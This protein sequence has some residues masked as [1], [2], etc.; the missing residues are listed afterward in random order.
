MFSVRL[1]SAA[2][3]DIAAV[4]ARNRSEFGAVAARR[5]AAVLDMTVADI[6]RDPTGA[7]SHPLPGSQRGT[8]TRHFASSNRTRVQSPRHLVMYR[9]ESDTVQILHIPREPMDVPRYA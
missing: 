8:R 5:Y 2:E 7:G 4:L 6:A 9:V 1:T 3:R